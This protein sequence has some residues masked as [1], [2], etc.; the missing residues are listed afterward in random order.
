V[1]DQ[2]EAKGEDQ[3]E[4]KPSVDSW[5]RD[6]QA[7]MLVDGQ[8]R[9]K[10]EAEEYMRQSA[11]RRAAYRKKTREDWVQTPQGKLC[12]ELYAKFH[13]YKKYLD[14]HPYARNRPDGP[15]VDF[16]EH[17]LFADALREVS[18]YQQERAEKDRENLKKAQLAA[19]CEHAYLDGDRCRAP[20][21][22][23]KKLCRMHE[24][25]EEAKALK[26]DLGPMEDPDS[27]Q[28]AIMKLQRTVIEDTL[29]TKK[30]SQLAYLIQLASWNVTR[31]TSGNRELADDAE[32]E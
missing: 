14:E 30:I 24:R 2:I 4:E 31:T 3:P 13:E 20:R 29:D 17:M 11:E 9:T 1:E 25:M 10:Q 28:V 18:D 23:G 5:D 8:L 12:L 22:K 19:R 32:I 6:P 21:L 27:I 7:K 26:L 15:K 16:P